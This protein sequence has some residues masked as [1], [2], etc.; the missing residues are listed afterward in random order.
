MPRRG[1]IPV[2]LRQ[3]QGVPL[4]AVQND[5]N[6]ENLQQGILQSAESAALNVPHSVVAEDGDPD[7][8]AA[9]STYAVGTYFE[10]KTGAELGLPVAEAGTV[11]VNTVKEKAD[12]GD[13]RAHQVA[14]GSQGRVYYRRS[15]SATTWLAWDSFGFKGELDAHVAAADPHPVYLLREESYS[16]GDLKSTLKS[17]ADPGWVLMNDGTIGNEDSGATT[18][19]DA[20]TLDLFVLLWQ[21]FD[22]TKCPVSGGRGGTA[23]GDFVAGK[24]IRLPLV[25]GRAI[26]VAGDGDSLTS[27]EL[28]DTVGAEQHTLLAEELP[29]VDSPEAELLL[30]ETQVFPVRADADGNDAPA[31]GP[32]MG[33][34]S[35]PQAAAVTFHISG[36]PGGE[37]EPH[38]NMQPTSFFN[39]MVKL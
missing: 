27:R 13:A 14:Y 10:I 37:D 32:L 35:T 9:P 25:R 2:S 28:G 34:S 18:R 5:N 8:D 22:N 3:D 36:F 31:N 30:D 4:D 21:G 38:N 24:T 12:T 1:S 17:T 11:L 16:T 33:W 6:L 26:A 29:S 23:N 7:T 19:A 15:S 20:D 39:L